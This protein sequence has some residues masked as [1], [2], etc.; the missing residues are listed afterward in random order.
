ME[1]K[2]KFNTFTEFCNRAEEILEVF[3]YLMTTNK[4]DWIKYKHY[5]YEEHTFSDNKERDMLAKDKCWL[6]LMSYKYEPMELNE[7]YCTLGQLK[8]GM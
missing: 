5:I 2:L 1:S 4:F 3:S 8:K 7:L 6:W